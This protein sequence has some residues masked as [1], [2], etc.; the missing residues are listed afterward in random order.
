MI[1]WQPIETAPRDGTNIML[2]YPLKEVNESWE[3]IVFCYWNKW[4]NNWVWSGRAR[5]TFSRGFQPTHWM[6]LPEP[7]E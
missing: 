1:D 5:R 3:G 6:P 2:Y 4:E 7:P